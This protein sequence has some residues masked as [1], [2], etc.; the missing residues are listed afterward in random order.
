MDMSKLT[1]R[2]KE[3]VNL[4]AQ[5]KPQRLIADQLVISRYTVYNH[6][7]NIKAKTGATS[8]FELAVNTRRQLTS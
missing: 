7:K 6:I 2:E 8:T 4:L 3:V 1:Q 5:G